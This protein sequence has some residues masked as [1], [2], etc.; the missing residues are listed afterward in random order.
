[1]SYT[2]QYLSITSP[3]PSSPPSLI[4]LSV[5]FLYHYSLHFLAF[6]LSLFSLISPTLLLYGA[7]WRLKKWF[8]SDIYFLTT[9]TD[10]IW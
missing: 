1:M 10:D 6:L 4:S 7:L 5:H 3:L 9:N 2:L 8:N